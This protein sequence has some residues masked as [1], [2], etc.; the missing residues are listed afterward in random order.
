MPEQIPFDFV[1]LPDM[2]R[3]APADSP[4]CDNCGCA[5]AAEDRI[6]TYDEQ[7]V[8]PECVLVCE[9]CEV[10]FSSDCDEIHTNCRQDYC[11]SSRRN[12]TSVRCDRCSFECADCGNRF[13]GS[14]ENSNSSDDPICYRCAENYRSCDRC[15]CILCSDDTHY[16]E[17]TESNYCEDCFNRVQSE[18]ADRVLFGYSYKPTPQFQSTAD[19]LASRRTPPFFLGVELEVDRDDVTDDV[20]DD[21]ESAHIPDAFYCKEDGSLTYGFEVVSHPCSF[22]WWQ[23]HSLY[24]CNSLVAAGYKSF[25][26]TTCGMH[27]HV[28]KAF[29]TESERAKLLMFAKTNRDFIRFISRRKPECLDRWAKVDQSSTARIIRK[30]KNLAS[31]ER[32][33]AINLLNR[34]TIEFRIFRG[35]LKPAA[36]KRNIAFVAAL[37]WFIKCCSNCELTHFHFRQWIAQHGRKYIGREMRDSLSEWI[38]RYHQNPLSRVDD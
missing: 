32:Y 28:S 2:P 34:A 19:E 25:K 26:T 35:T 11:L 10:P 38:G 24:W 7:D 14:S 4:T 6:H 31:D 30:V 17:D 18:R 5:V 22:A 13:A 12:L 1:A 20:K 16:F 9:G 21:I 29:L 33:E 27:V 3:I 23:E 15:G 36:I 8:C 37:C